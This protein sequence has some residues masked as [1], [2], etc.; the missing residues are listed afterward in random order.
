MIY[1]LCSQQRIQFP[2]WYRELADLTRSAWSDDQ[3]TYHFPYRALADPDYWQQTMLCG[4]EQE[5]SF[6][7]I[8]VHE[9]RIIG[10]VALMN[11][12]DHWEMGRMVAYEHAP[13]GIMSQLVL[14]ADAFARQH[15][16]IY[17]VECTQAHTSSQWIC[18][19]VLELRYGGISVLD[20]EDADVSKARWD[21]IHFDNRFDLAD[22]QP[23]RGVLA[24]PCGIE[25]RCQ[26]IHVPRLLEIGGCI[27]IERGGH[28]PPRQFHTLERLVP[29][30]RQIINLNVAKAA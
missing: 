25:I 24:N 8:Y 28:L 17:V 27:T 16:I 19:E 3:G 23:Q 1:Q 5:T 30:I 15:G 14:I 4:Y 21:V 29:V 9:G 20:H 6:S 26:A 7:W 22:F 13:H 10:H 11:K 12:G 18:A 2:K